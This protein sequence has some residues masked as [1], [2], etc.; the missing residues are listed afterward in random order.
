MTNTKQKWKNRESGIELLRLIAMFLIVV[1][2]MIMSFCYTS[3]Y[4]PDTAYV[5]PI[6]TVTKDWQRITIVFLRH[7]GNLG[8]MIFFICSA[9]FLIRTEKMDKRK[10]FRLLL[11]NWVISMTICFIVIGI[12]RG[13][14]YDSVIKC[15]FPFLH[16]NNWFISCYLIFLIIAPFLNMIIRSTNKKTLFRFMLSMVI[17]ALLMG[18]VLRDSLFMSQVVDWFVLYFV[19]AYVKLY[20]PGFSSRKASNVYLFFAGFLGLLATILV[21]DMLAMA[22]GEAKMNVLNW[23][24][25]CNPF[26]AAMALGLFNLFRQIKLKSQIINYTAS[27]SLF[28]YLIHENILIRN[29]YRPIIW[30]KVYE[31]WGYSFILL[32]LM[33]LSLGVFLVSILLSIF[34]D[35]TIRRVVIKVG[36]RLY[37]LGRRIYLKIEKRAI[38]E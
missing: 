5:M 19:V 28:V 1:N 21:S 22:A 23:N 29:L 15:L 20:A 6:N 16:S 34:Y 2:H 31:N 11:D 38:S 25:V 4:F 26:I 12:E 27:L 18:Y 35:Q 17:I 13:L 36:E 7:G 3:A 8:V 37:D 9:W 24:V 33:I 10:W 14:D 32:K 30:Q